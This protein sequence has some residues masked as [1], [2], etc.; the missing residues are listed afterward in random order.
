MKRVDFTI[1]TL[2]I[3]IILSACNEKIAYDK[4]NHTPIAGWEKNDTLSFDISHIA[5]EGRYHSDLGLRINGAYPF[6]RLS[7]I[8]EQTVYPD[9]RVKIDT[10]NCRL[11]DEN[12]IA[13]GQGVNYY[14]YN[15]PVSELYLKQGDSIHVN[16]R[17]D[18]QRE[19]LPGISEIGFMLTAY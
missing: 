13:K 3:L 1:L 8:V 12:G 6:M 2:I 18:M 16:I 4:Y 10:I 19:I 17:H 9:K 15:F 7:L 5:K 11:I 14:Q